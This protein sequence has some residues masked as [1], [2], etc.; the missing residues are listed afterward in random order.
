MGARVAPSVWV[1]LKTVNTT[2]MFIKN[3]PPEKPAERET[4]KDQ[5]D[6]LFGKRLQGCPDCNHQ[7]SINAYQCP[8]C[9]LRLKISP[10]NQLARIILF[11]VIAGILITILL[12][13]LGGV[14]GLVGAR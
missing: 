7:V 4:K 3:E 11:L 8:S 13:A 5:L 1:G 2:V 6:R 14:G 12:S 9:G 10:I